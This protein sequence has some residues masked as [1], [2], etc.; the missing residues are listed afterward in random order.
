MSE[1]KT[2]LTAADAVKLFAKQNI[3][4]TVVKTTK[5]GER[6]RDPETKRYVTEEVPLAAAHILG[7]N[8]RDGGVRV[9]TIDG[10]KYTAK[11]A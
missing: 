10:R 9:V 2:A 3:A 5:G 6:V 8:E 11:A 7:I 1:P 4:V